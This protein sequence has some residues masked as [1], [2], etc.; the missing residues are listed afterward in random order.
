MPPAPAVRTTSELD[1]ELKAIE[2]KQ[3]KMA[4]LLK[5]D[6]ED[7]SLLAC[8]E[9][10]KKRHEAKKQEMFSSKDLGERLRGNHQRRSRLKDEVASFIE[11][12]VLP[13][14]VREQRLS[15]PDVPAAFLDPGVRKSRPRYLRLIHRPVRCGVLCFGTTRLCDVGL[16]AVSKKGG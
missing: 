2:G 3:R 8:V 7:A 11:K 4:E 12:S 5:A 15:A 13:T 1:A 9:D 10:L 16:F 14:E 6:P